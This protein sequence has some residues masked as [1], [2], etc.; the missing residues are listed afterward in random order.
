MET[1][2]AMA[3][4][5]TDDQRPPYDRVAEVERLLAEDDTVLGHV[6]R[7]R[8]EGLTPEQMSEREGGIAAAHFLPRYDELIRVLRDGR[9]SNSPSRASES[10]QR[11]RSWLRQKPLSAQLRAQLT[12]QEQ[13]L[14]LRANDTQGFGS[15]EVDED[16]ETALGRK[17]REAIALCRDVLADR[18]RFD[19]QEVTYKHEIAANI[20]AAL[21]AAEGEQPIVPAL[22]KALGKPNNLLDLR[23]AGARFSEWMQDEGTARRALL[24]I[25]GAGSTAERVDGFIAAIPPEVLTTPGNK[26]AFAS[27]FLMGADP[28]AYPMYRPR[29]I[30]G[31]ERILGWPEASR[32]STPG[33]QYEHHVAFVAEFRDRLVEAG[34]RRARHAR[35]TGPDLD[36]DEV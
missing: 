25:R 26:I 31:A 3:D 1:G 10:A 7:Y 27:F 9:V 13:L 14:T 6:W 8:Q 33:Q 23:F 4:A 5:P 15:Q 11:V 32:D 2:F 24:S 16:A 17:W 34:P 35:R 18:K 12:E 20:R 28:A 19:E 36:V 29:A 30:K 21:E 22:K